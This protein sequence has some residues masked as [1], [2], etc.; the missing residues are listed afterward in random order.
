MKRGV[1]GSATQSADQG[2]VWVFA[3]GSNMHVPE[4]LRA[5]KERGVPE[6]GLLESVPAVALGLRLEWNYYSEGRRAGAANVM[7]SVG[8]S[9]EGVG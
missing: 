2:D 3:Y 6:S 8:A 7:R 1:P 9:L 4:V 5:F